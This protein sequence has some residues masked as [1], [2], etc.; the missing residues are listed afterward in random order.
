MIEGFPP[1]PITLSMKIWVAVVPIIY[2]FLVI[3][4]RILNWWPEKTRRGS[5]GILSILDMI[6]LIKGRI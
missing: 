1:I 6:E 2:F 4:F 5:R 3:F